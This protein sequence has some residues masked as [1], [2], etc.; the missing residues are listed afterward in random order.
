V[1]ADRSYLLLETGH[2]RIVDLSWLA[3]AAKSADGNHQKLLVEYPTLSHVWYPSFH[4]PYV[5]GMEFIAGNS[6][7]YGACMAQRAALPSLREFMS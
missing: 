5:D 4:L 3:T 2:A 7:Y 1:A 6:G